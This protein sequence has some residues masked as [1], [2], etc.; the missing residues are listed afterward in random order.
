MNL[1]L[2]VSHLHV[3]AFG[4]P[5][6]WLTGRRGFLRWFRREWEPQYIAL[7][8][9]AVVFGGL[10]SSLLSALIKEEGWGGAFM[11]HPLRAT[12]YLAV[13]V[14]CAIVTTVVVVR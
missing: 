5:M 12:M 6:G 9:V 3:M 7:V 2:L 11:R 8:V 4:L 1:L 13:V 10:L 14:A